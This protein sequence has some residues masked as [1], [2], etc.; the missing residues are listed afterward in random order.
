MHQTAVLSTADRRH[1][2]RKNK[3]KRK[4][5]KANELKQHNHLRFKTVKESGV[6]LDK[7]NFL[8]S[9]CVPVPDFQVDE[10]YPEGEKGRLPNT[11]VISNEDVLE[12]YFECFIGDTNSPAF[13]S[14]IWV[15]L[16]IGRAHV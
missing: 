15:A 16:R 2:K 8:S 3:I 9:L 4:T 14:E 11:K 5:E 10:L 13:R 7:R 6:P 12:V 1:S